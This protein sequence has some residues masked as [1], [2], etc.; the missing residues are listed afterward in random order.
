MYD[1][2]I[3][4][5]WDYYAQHKRDLPWRKDIT[6]Y[7][8]VISEVMLQQTQVS[9]II[10]KYEPFITELPNF[11]TLA[12]ASLPVL[13]ELWQGIGYNRRAIYLQRL[14]QRVVEEYNGQLP[15]N[16]II[17]DTFPGIG[18]ATAASICV[19]AFNKPIPFIETN[20]RRI[21]IHHFFHDRTDIDDREIM[22]FVQKTLDT[23]NPREWY[24]ALMDYGTMLG[25]TIDNPNKRSKHYSIQSQFEGSDRQIRG[26]V[27][28][29]LLNQSVDKQELYTVLAKDESRVDKVI[30][31]LE[32][33]GFIIEE[34]GMYRIKD[35]SRV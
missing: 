32:K 24:Y 30:T 31:Q 33:E 35:E 7:N 10:T 15:D 22:P 1:K 27:L 12:D 2:F 25:R 23:E 5:V 19:Y 18:E 13:L 26:M 16:P 21:Y 14:A 8:I 4:T 6:P 20:V 34:G 29:K 9:R 3:A 11:Q 28:K 17:L